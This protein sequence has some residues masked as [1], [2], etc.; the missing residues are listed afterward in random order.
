[1]ANA[2]QAYPSIEIV[3]ADRTRVFCLNLGGFRALEQHLAEKS[4][5]P[6][7]SILEDFDWSS[8]TFENVELMIWAGLYTDAQEHDK[9]PFTVQ[10]AGR[11][12]SLLGVVEARHCVDESLERVMSPE[13]YA[14]MKEDAEKKRARKAAS[15][16]KSSRKRK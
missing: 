14:K 11:V 5:N 13:Q 12:V 3:C 6:E 4:G 16:I 15:Q 1:M 10:K 8:K 2:K 9:E 7:F